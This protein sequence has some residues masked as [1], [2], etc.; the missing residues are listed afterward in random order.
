MYS[1][2]GGGDDMLGGD[3]G[4]RRDPGRVVRSFKEF[5]KTHFVHDRRETED[6]LLYR[7]E[8]RPHRARGAQI[9]RAAPR[10]RGLRRGRVSSS[11]A[12]AWIT[13]ARARVPGPTRPRPHPPTPLPY[14]LPP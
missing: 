5:V 3:D 11:R 14:P 6:P 8:R 2:Y 4:G 7:R 9:A 10:A 13:A 12:A 1:N